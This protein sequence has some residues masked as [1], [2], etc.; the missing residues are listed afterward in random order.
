MGGT[1]QSVALWSPKGGV[2][3]SV[4]AAALALKLAERQPTVLID[5]NPEN[6]DVTSLLRVPGYPNVTSWTPPSGR[7]EL[8]SRLVRHSNRLWVLPGPPRYVEEGALTGPVMESVLEACIGAGFT[9][10]VDLGVSLRDST[11]AAL[12]RVDRVLIPV[13]PDLLAVA[14]LR[15][16]RAELDLLR[17]PESKFRVVVNRLTNSGEITLE[18]IEA[19]SDFA[20]AGVVPHSPELAAAVNRGEFALALG[21][22]TPVGRAVASLTA[23]LLD[24]EPVVLARPRRLLGG[25]LLSL[26]RGGT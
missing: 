1:L 19:F 15:R 9:V 12:D 8:E 13:T 25:L 21:A 7:A 23:P 6:P 24:E 22:D 16:I 18:D 14:P 2:G 5:G 4:L 20:V 11:V 3:K 17:M 26:R 10:V